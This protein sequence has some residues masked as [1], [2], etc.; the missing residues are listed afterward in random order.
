MTHEQVLEMEAGG[1]LAD[2][3]PA[4][5][6]DLDDLAGVHDADAEGAEHDECDLAAVGGLVRL[7]L[8]HIQ[9]L[10]VLAHDDQ[11]HGASGAGH[12][13]DG[14]HVGV[15]LEALAEGHNRRRVALGSDRGGGHGAEE[16]PVAVGFQ[17]SDRVL[18]ERDPL[19][20]EGVPAGLVVR[21]AELEAEGGGQ[22]LEDAAARGDDFAA[23]AVAGDEAWCA[24]LASML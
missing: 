8:L 10:R 2:L 7:F 21:E 4:T 15:Q 16:G 20:L 18:G 19:L 6:T 11:V 23:D 22:R 24:Q 3:L 12:A 5:V 17:C 14:P 13:L 9:I 1:G